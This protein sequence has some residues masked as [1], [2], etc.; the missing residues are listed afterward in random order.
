MKIILLAGGGGTRLFP[1][2]RTRFPKQFLKVTGD[3]SLFAQTVQRFLAV[4]DAR[5]LVVITNQ[6]HEHLVKAELA[7]CGASEA[8]VALEPEG[9]NT[10]PAIALAAAWCRDKLGA[11]AEEVLFVTPCDHVI[12]P[13]D[14]FAAGVLEAVKLAAKG[15]IVTFG[16]TP[17]GPETG[18]G[19]IQAGDSV[20]G[21]FAVTSFREKP[22]RETAEKYVASGNY[23][24]NSGMFSF[25]M[26]RFLQ[27]LAVQQPEISELTAQPVETVLEQFARMPDV[28]IDYG[29]MEKAADV[30][31]IPLTAYWNDIGSWDAIYD[32]LGKD[33]A[34]NAVKG[35]CINI[36]CTNTLILSH[37]HLVAGIGLEDMLVVETADAIL[38]AKKGESQKVKEVV[39]QLK[40]K[41]RREASEHLTDYRP[42]GS[43]TILGE[44]PDYKIKRIVVNPGQILSL[45]MHHH[46]SE[47]WVVVSG[48]AL[49]TIGD[50]EQLVCDNESVFVPQT[51][52]HR[53]A[54][55]GK[56][57][58]VLIEVQ[59]GRYLGEDDIV[60]FEDI[61]GRSGR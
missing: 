54:N 33:G 41:G 1:L 60:R 8:H 45:Q 44:G 52:K 27:E 49:V 30:L 37:K 7:A 5:N 20:N 56:I 53:L 12:R 48:T 21:A 29:I 34:G 40:A 25:T 59:S 17:T 42:W 47:H 39:A 9:R 50:R 38:V 43:Y 13:V 51:V 15:G 19:Y 16:I 4:T 24:W 2:S 22:D 61:Y 14:V 6:A 28:S 23:Y 18:Y 31:V 10:A 36:G 46:R 11:T 3:E 57:P 35:D 55:T 26:G 58:L 32:V